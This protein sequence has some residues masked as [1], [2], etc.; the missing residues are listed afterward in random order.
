M[1]MDSVRLDIWLWAAR[2]FKTRSQAK[3]ACELGRVRVHGQP[4]KP[5]RDVH[6]GDRLRVSNDSGDFELEVLQLSSMRGPAAVAQTLYR[7]SEESRV[8][9]QKLAE[10][11]KAARAF[12]ALP[13]NRPTKRDRRLIMRL[14][15]RDR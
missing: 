1:T 5:G 14:R 15:G 2:F 9:R 7:E 8:A 10:A 12:E 6:V 4:A 11:Q 3:R 13:E